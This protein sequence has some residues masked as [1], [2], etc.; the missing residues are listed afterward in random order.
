M[1]FVLRGQVH[2]LTNL[3]DAFMMPITVKLLQIFLKTH[4][5]HALHMIKKT[6]PLGDHIC[7]II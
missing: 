2:G 3:K 6:K 7:I 5:L 4:S 1:D